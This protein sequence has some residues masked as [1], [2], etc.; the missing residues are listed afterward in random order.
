MHRS[1]GICFLHFDLM[2]Y[3]PPFEGASNHEN[4]V[5]NISLMQAVVL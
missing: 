1:A 2:T 4:Q 5:K 3:T